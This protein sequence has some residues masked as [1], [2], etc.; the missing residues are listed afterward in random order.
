M[1]STEQASLLNGN[2]S[3]GPIRSV[4]V[5][6][7]GFSGVS[8]AAHLLLAGIDVT[9][10]ERSGVVGGVWHYDSRLPLTPPFPNLTPPAADS[11][12]NSPPEGLTADEASIYHAS[13]TPCYAGLR[14]NIFISVM[15][16]SLLEWPE[17]TEELTSAEAV[18]RYIEDISRRYGVLDHT[19]LWTKVEKI[20]KKPGDA[21]WSV[22]TSKFTQTG[23][24]ATYD[25][26]LW[27][28]DSVVVA[29]G[30]FD[31]PRVPDIPGLSTWQALFPDRVTHSKGY[32]NADPYKGSTVLLLG[33]G[34]SSSDIATEVHAVGG[35][36]YQ[37]TRDLKRSSSAQSEGL[38]ESCERVRTIKEFKLDLDPTTQSPRQPLQASDTI[39]GRVVMEDGREITDLHYIIV[40][41]GYV[42]SYPFL[43]E[44][45][46]PNLSPEEA[47]EEVIITRD[48]YTTHNLHKDIFY[49][50][51]PTLAFVGVQHNVSTFSIYDFQAR[52]VASVF[53]GYAQLL[54]K[55]ELRRLYRER[56]EKHQAEKGQKFHSLLMKDVS[57]AESILEWVNAGLKSAGQPEIVPYDDKWYVGFEK[58]RALYAPRRPD[59]LPPE[60]NQLTS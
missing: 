29:S 50:P 28:F 58:M 19:Q 40:C 25:R 5:I 18:R 8:A 11:R 51:V 47:D 22:Q 6:G 32:R 57:Y 4:A 33:A 42:T 55:H 2:L 7:S 48:G 38:P 60:T 3:I 10:F 1:G 53:K 45:Q 15:R 21:S 14:N 54:P 31:V 35:R 43:G 20:S 30:H 26:R 17:G 52:V 56:K 27:T 39:P 59:L 37:V 9:V 46:Q 13:P 24:G 41:T 44:L 16:S 12:Y 49:I 34:T 23:D 36:T